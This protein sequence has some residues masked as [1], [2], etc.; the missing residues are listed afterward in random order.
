MIVRNEVGKVIG[1]VYTLSSLRQPNEMMTETHCEKAV[2]RQGAVLAGRG[3]P[4]AKT[5][6]YP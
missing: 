4:K 1:L 6:R 3:R 2:K 5:M